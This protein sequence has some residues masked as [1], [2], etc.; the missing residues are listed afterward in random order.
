MLNEVGQEENAQDEIV[1]L[2]NHHAM[3]TNAEWR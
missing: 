1:F 2:L 3:K